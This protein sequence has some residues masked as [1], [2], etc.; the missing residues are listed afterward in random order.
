MLTWMCSNAVLK[1]GDT[2]LGDNCSSSAEKQFI[3]LGCG[4]GH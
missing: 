3:V 4:Q 2:Y 1:L